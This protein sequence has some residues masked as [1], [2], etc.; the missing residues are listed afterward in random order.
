V[1]STLRVLLLDEVWGTKTRGTLLFSGARVV[2]LG[3]DA[4]G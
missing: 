4:W 1:E 3:E 2:V